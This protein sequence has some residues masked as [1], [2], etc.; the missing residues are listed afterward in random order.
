MIRL[1]LLLFISPAV[2][3]FG[4]CA[5]FDNIISLKPHKNFETAMPF[6]WKYCKKAKSPTV[7]CYEN[8]L[9]GQYTWA[10]QYPTCAGSQQSPIN[11]PLR[12]VYSKSGVVT[13]PGYPATYFSLPAGCTEN[14][15]E[16]EEGFSIAMKLKFQTQCCAG[17]TKWKDDL[18]TVSDGNHSVLL[19]QTVGFALDSQGEVLLDSHSHSANVEFCKYIS[20]DQEPG[21]SI[22]YEA[23]LKPL[24]LANY[25]HIVYGD[26][27]NT[28]SVAK[29]YVSGAT[30][31][32]GPLDQEYDIAQLHFHWGATNI[33]GSEHLLNGKSFPLEMHIVH[34]KG[35]DIAVAGFFFEIDNS[36]N[37][38]LQ[39]MLDL[40][41][42]IKNSDTK[43]Q[44]RNFALTKLLAG[45]APLGSAPT[46]AYTTYTGSLTT[47]PCTE[48]VKW[49]N[50][51]T[52]LKISVSQMEIF[53]TLLK[54]NGKPIKYNYR[55]VQLLNGR[56]VSKI[57]ET[58]PAP[59]GL[60][61]PYYTPSTYCVKKIVTGDY[62]DAR[63][64]AANV[65]ESTMSSWLG[66]SSLPGSF[67]MDMGCQKERSILEL[68]NTVDGNRATKN[69]R[70]LSSASFMGP[71]AV[72]VEGKM[73]KME[74]PP[75]PME[76]FSF[77]ST[78]DQFYKFEIVDWYGNGGGLQYF[79]VKD[80]AEGG[81]CSSARFFKDD[82]DLTINGTV[83]FL[84][85]PGARSSLNYVIFSI[86]LSGEVDG[87]KFSVGLTKKGAVKPLANHFLAKNINK[88]LLNTSWVKN[89][90]IFGFSFE[91]DEDT[92]DSYLLD[93]YV[94]V[95][96]ED[97]KVIGCTS[98]RL[99]TGAP[100]V[101]PTEVILITGGDY[102]NED[103]T[104]FSVEIYNPLT[105]KSCDIGANLTLKDHA[106]FGMTVCGGYEPGGFGK[107]KNCSRM[108]IEDGIGTFEVI[109]DLNL[110]I[111]PDYLDYAWASSD[112]HVICGKESCDLLKADDTLK[113]SWIV[114]EPKPEKACIVTDSLDDSMILIGGKVEGKA[115]G[116]VD[117]YKKQSEK[118][119]Q[120]EKVEHLPDLINPRYSHGCAGYRDKQGELVVLVAGG[121]WPGLDSDEAI[122]RTEVLLPP[123]LAW[124]VVKPLPATYV[125]LTNALLTVNNM[126]FLLGGQGAESA[127]NATDAVLEWNNDKLEWRQ[128]GSVLLSPRIN[129]AVG[130]IAYAHWDLCD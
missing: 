127:V 93:Y 64:G 47:P 11:I 8:K 12:S 13:S 121:F 60:R 73:E 42:N 16:V 79:D 54:A 84:R 33:R 81:H 59:Y 113:E 29:L 52:P 9:C 101:P 109:E 94:V 3:G 85:A 25:N 67:I 92:M 24:K 65:F 61:Q 125:G 105:G 123:G 66:P 57:D 78:T 102:D 96:N 51:L 1:F 130:A 17:Y 111:D 10:K 77:E 120:A 70:L 106:Q 55:G 99:S 83:E 23:C 58:V 56:A 89:D 116:I 112:G 28:G 44:M 49:I 22:S 126:V 35:D 50:F 108:T 124:K 91:E 104:A 87:D 122:D 118:A 38:D 48:G 86:R 19:D 110:S 69:F 88:N 31:S 74:N 20:V 128:P 4:I 63:Y 7:W 75:P 34:T 76:T 36:D 119:E 53:R 72:L 40:F 27:K 30:M 15:I 18:I 103:S 107:P 100:P 62:F 114:L 2:R 115:S 37:A 45:I 46:T 98:G 21:Y 5:T 80:C 95:I 82:F 43:I 6:L 97:D 39:P 71:W 41:P 117:R 129:H 68:I 90:Q 14:N 32:G 26:L